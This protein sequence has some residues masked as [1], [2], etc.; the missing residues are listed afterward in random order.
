MYIV[1]KKENYIMKRRMNKRN[2]IFVVLMASLIFTTAWVQ[3]V[4]NIKDELIK[5]HVTVTTINDDG[6]EEIHNYV[7]EDGH[8][9]SIDK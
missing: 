2:R 9:V 7:I 1:K 3:T 6:S 4:I 5:E 8:Y